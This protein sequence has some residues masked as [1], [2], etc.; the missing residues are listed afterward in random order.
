M[1]T[2]VFPDIPG[3]MGL[4]STKQLLK[5]GASEWDLTQLA[6][7][8]QRVVRAVYRS[9]TGAFSTSQLLMAGSLWAGPHAVLTGG[10]ALTCHG[11]EPRLDPVLQPRFL[12]PPQHRARRNALGMVSE[13][14]RSM[15]RGL[16]KSGIRI[17]P[18][19]R[20]LVDAARRREVAPTCRRRLKTRP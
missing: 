15:P 4:A 17:A 11:L 20:A 16:L 7:K 14:T 9:G 2:F 19:D 8:G 18:A 12:V 1:P 10:H 6:L 13:R 5:A 3:Q